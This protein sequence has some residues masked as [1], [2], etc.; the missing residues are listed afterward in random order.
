MVEYIVDCDDNFKKIISKLDQSMKI[1]VK[2]QIKKIIENPLV[3]K[4]MCNVRK[5]TREVYVK[6]YRLS[7]YFIKN[8]N[9]IIFLDFYHKD[10]Q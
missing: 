7:Y 3:G 1:K 8:E 5:G 9:L 4:P 2:K 6:P 10:K